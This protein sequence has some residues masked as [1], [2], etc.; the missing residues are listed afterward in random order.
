MV[1]MVASRRGFVVSKLAITTLAVSGLLLVAC[2]SEQETA[3]SPPPATPIPVDE[4]TSPSGVVTSIGAVVPDATTPTTDGDTIVVPITIAAVTIATGPVGTGS[5]VATPVTPAPTAATCLGNTT[6]PTGV[7]IGDQIVGDAD[8]D[9]VDDTVT[10]YTGT[11]GLPHVFLQR[12]GANA[13]DVTLP[14]GNAG[15]VSISWEDVDYSLGASVAP[16]KV[17]LA[18]GVGPAG[19]APATFL[20]PDPSSGSGRCL[21]QWR[22]AGEPFAF[23]IDQRGPFSG[24]LCDGAAGRRYYVLR[25]ATP[26]GLGAVSVTSREI[27][28]DGLE[29]TLKELGDET[30]PDDPAVQYNFGDIQ[31]CDHPPLFADLPAIPIATTT[32]MAA[33]TTS[34]SG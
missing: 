25:T 15:T 16:P 31:N 22:L 8:G 7:V 26:D 10:E 27:D 21:T 19:S 34:I 28:H 6:L 20:S 29:V 32:T 13:S 1:R 30:I 2:G 33:S 5:T 17:I 3:T 24:L 11:D 14:L 4:L 18:I 23:A 9:G 12:G